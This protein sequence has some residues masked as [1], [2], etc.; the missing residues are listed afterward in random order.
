VN[1]EFDIV[2]EVALIVPELTS[3]KTALGIVIA[4]KARLPETLKD[5]VLIFV[6]V[7]LFELRFPRVIK[8]SVKSKLYNNF[9][10]VILV[11]YKL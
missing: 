4:L 6:E 1:R 3:V 10:L 9:L 7:I 8:L 11:N 5:D 2:L